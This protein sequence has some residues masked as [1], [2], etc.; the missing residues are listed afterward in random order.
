MKIIHDIEAC[1]GCG[2]CAAICPEHFEMNSDGKA[3]LKDSTPAEDG[4]T[5]KELEDIGCGQEAADSCPVDC[6]H[7][8]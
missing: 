7:I 5:E 3:Q 8:I 2:A 4:K 6:I 1:I